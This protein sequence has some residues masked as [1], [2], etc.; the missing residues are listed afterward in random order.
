MIKIKTASLTIQNLSK[1][2]KPQVLYIKT[3]HKNI[4]NPRFVPL[5][6]FHDEMCVFDKLMDFLKI[7]DMLMIKDLN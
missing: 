4:S 3:F 2:N 5:N 7:F 6:F 1:L